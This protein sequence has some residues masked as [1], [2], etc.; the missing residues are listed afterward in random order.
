MTVTSGDQPGRPHPS[1]RGRVAAAGYTSSDRA[2]TPAPV[3]NRE[4]H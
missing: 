1:F 2:S 4:T 3:G